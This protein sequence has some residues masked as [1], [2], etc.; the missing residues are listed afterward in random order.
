MSQLDIQRAKRRKTHQIKQLLSKERPLDELTLA[1]AERNGHELGFVMPAKGEL[2]LCRQCALHSGA[3]TWGALRHRVR[4]YTVGS[5]VASIAAAGV[6]SRTYPI[7]R[8]SQAK[9]K[10]CIPLNSPIHLKSDDGARRWVIYPDRVRIFRHIDPADALDPLTVF[11]FLGRGFD[12][13][14][15]RMYIGCGFG[16][17]PSVSMWGEMHIGALNEHKTV[18]VKWHQLDPETRAHMRRRIVE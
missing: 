14:M 16:R 13:D 6:P 1:I 17:N 11:P 7:E 15:Q 12:P 4:M 8:A 3:G 10:D 18:E 2:V 5:L 9:C